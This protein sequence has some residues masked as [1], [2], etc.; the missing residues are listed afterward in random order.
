MGDDLSALTDG[1]LRELAAKWQAEA[2]HYRR[3]AAATFALVTDV[4][5]EVKRREL[6]PKK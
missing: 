6:E 5:D 4:L 3:M 1:D 2:L